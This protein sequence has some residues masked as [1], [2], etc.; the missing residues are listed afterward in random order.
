MPCMLNTN[1]IKTW[2]H[3]FFNISAYNV[4]PHPVEFLLENQKANPY[5]FNISL[6]HFP[7]P[8]NIDG[9]NYNCSG[10]ARPYNYMEWMLTMKP[11]KGSFI[12]AIVP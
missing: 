7:C 1:L 5:F 2:A 12:N 11:G 8:L 9:T 6:H 4:A 3:I 10:D